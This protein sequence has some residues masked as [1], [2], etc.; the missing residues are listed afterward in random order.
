MAAGHAHSGHVASARTHVTCAQHA[1]PIRAH[2]AGS[3]PTHVSYRALGATH[4]GLL[5]TGSLY[6]LE[7][8]TLENW[9]VNCLRTMFCIMTGLTIIIT[10]IDGFVAMMITVFI[11][12][13]LTNRTRRGNNTDWWW[14]SNRSDYGSLV[15]WT[16]IWLLFLYM[17]KKPRTTSLFEWSSK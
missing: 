4:A 8:T 15:N 17:I 11:S 13:L 1:C 9:I 16:L 3:G 10:S 5:R 7:Y 12:T 14:C 6:H 2:G